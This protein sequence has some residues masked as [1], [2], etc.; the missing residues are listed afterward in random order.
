VSREYVC[1]KCARAMARGFIPDVSHGNAVSSWVEGEPE[2]SMWLGVKIP[3]E[4]V[5]SIT[6]Y[7]CVGCGFL[8]SYA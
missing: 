2:H 6:T 8:E 7:R 4:K 5:L 1:P 3:E